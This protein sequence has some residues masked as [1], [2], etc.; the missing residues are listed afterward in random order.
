MNHSGL[1]LIAA[2]VM[3]VSSSVALADDP[4]SLD[5]ALSDKSYFVEGSFTNVALNDA[6]LDAS[7]SISEVDSISL[8][9]LNT[10]D[11][12]ASNRIATTV[13]GAAN[14][15]SVRI[16]EEEYYASGMEE[17]S[18]TWDDDKN[19][20]FTTS[21]YDARDEHEEGTD[22]DGIY[23]IDP[24][25]SNSQDLETFDLSYGFVYDDQLDAAYAAQGTE[26]S[27]TVPEIVALNAAYNSSALDASINVAVDRHEDGNF[28]G[29]NIDFSTSAT[30][31]VLSGDLEIG[32]MGDQVLLD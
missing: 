5:D 22:A 11:L 24:H 28:Q 29:Q 25:M 8:A 10:D 2:G 26:A 1:K 19:G 17:G 21:W 4:R 13:L 32:F 12:V 7:V 27:A 23:D 14:T 18:L 30:G 15:G 3:A 6:K 9:A 16:G 20:L 31:A